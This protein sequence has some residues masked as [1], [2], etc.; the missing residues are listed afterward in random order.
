MQGRLSRSLKVIL[1]FIETLVD[2]EFRTKKLG[3]FQQVPSIKSFISATEVSVLMLEGLNIYKSSKG[4]VNN[5][6]KGVVN[7]NQ[8]LSIKKVEL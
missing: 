2:R 4:V 1:I 8:M 5:N 6:Q 3:R 7:N